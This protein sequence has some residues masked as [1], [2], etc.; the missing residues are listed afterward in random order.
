M[1]KTYKIL[2]ND[3]KGTDIQPVRVVQGAGANGEPVRMLAKRGWRF[4]LQDD[5]KGKSVAPDQVRVKRVGKSLTLM[6][7]GSQRADVVIEDFYADNTDA[8]KDNGMPK[9]VGNAENGGMY[10]Y[11][12]QDPAI[13]CMPAELKDGNTPVIVSLGGGPLGD[14]F[15][16]SALPLVAA[17]GG[18]SG[19]L[20]AGGVAAAAAAGGGGGGG[21]S[22]AAVVVVPAKATG[23]LIHDATND[24][25]VLP[26]D[27][28]T[29]NKTP[30]L[31]INAEHGAKVVVTV[32]GKEYTATETSTAGVYTVPVTDELKDG[33]YTPTI[34]VTNSAGSTTSDGTPFIVDLSTF[35]DPSDAKKSGLQI[36]IDNDSNNDGFINSEELP[37]TKLLQATVALT[38]DAAVGDKLTVQATGNATRTID[39]TQE[40][41]SAGKVVVKDITAPA[42]GQSIT[43]SASIN[44]AAGNAS[45]APDVSDTAKIDVT[46][47]GGIAP[48]VLIV[49]D[50]DNN[51][52]LD[53]N[54][55]LKNKQLS[56]T[57]SFNKDKVAANDKVV[58]G[59]GQ[60][61][62]LTADQAKSGAVTF[63][64]D[65]PKDGKTLVVPAHIETP[66]GNKTPD[67]SD[68]ISIDSNAINK[69]VIAI[70]SITDDTGAPDF[71]TSD[72][73]LIYG[74]T[75]SKF[76]DNGAK[77]QLLLHK[78]DG[79]VVDVSD[80]A[81]ISGV[82]AA[83]KTA[84]W[85][86]DR[87]AIGQQDGEYKLT[88]TLVNEVGAQIPGNTQA[89]KT[90][91][92]SHDSLKAIDDAVTVVE[93][94][95][96]SNG[97]KG[98]APL[99][100]SNLLLNDTT[101]IPAITKVAKPQEKTQTTY[102]TFTLNT[103]GTYDYV[104]NQSDSRIQALTGLADSLIDKVKYTVVDSTGQS[105][106]AYLVI[107]IK[108]Q[109]D[110]PEFFGGS[111]LRVSSNETNLI[112]SSLKLVDVDKNQSEFHLPLHTAGVYGDFSFDQVAK[113]WAY[114]VNGA[115][116]ATKSLNSTFHG[117]DVTAVVS[118]D[119]T[120]AQTLQVEVSAGAG[121]GAPQVFNLVNTDRV[122]LAGDSSSG[123]IDTIVLPATNMSLD[124]AAAT[125]KITHIEQVDLGANSKNTLILNLANLLESDT[126]TLTVFGGKD[127]T[128][129]F[130]GAIHKTTTDTTVNGLAFV[131]YHYSTTVNN[132]S[133]ELDLLVQKTIVLGGIS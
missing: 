64:I 1:A 39:L 20:V 105:A 44:D 25:G 66:A 121:Q 79:T 101:L 75:L 22:G 130:S 120:I 15:V 102:G 40:Q 50:T 36:T 92:I 94:G 26:T 52:F 84:S 11:V 27:S 6:F 132:Q 28:I 69:A 12:P 85:G 76:T 14:D 99:G 46:P 110:V 30:V 73:G 65:P 117:Y 81:V 43:V 33:K 16:L 129:S 104:L 3:G 5:L 78:M 59:D 31:T 96:V 115:N 2:V 34:K 51:G 9:L 70:T 97:T 83:N 122:T 77:V 123:V 128:V 89:E 62:E 55:T 126:H 88:A 13:S 95:G 131:D 19:W 57:V 98:G 38:K 113:T 48:T 109:N 49:E 108:G 74:G 114:T 17:A 60:F 61:I 47:N 63:N 8:D 72:S 53:G 127:D 93:D 23:S 80:F 86:W 125:N 112:L 116:A 32:N 37:T 7:D 111:F 4:E 42:E 45:P 87:H 133:V 118:L 68:Q 124:M 18:V 119:D 82:D 35:T 10:E 71:I 106:D 29:N 100:D 91:V 56:V 54:E 21:G 107:T 90:I 24:T 103:D 58:L 41:I 67:G